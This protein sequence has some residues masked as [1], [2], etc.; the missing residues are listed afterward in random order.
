MHKFSFLF[1]ILLLTLTLPAQQDKASEREVLKSIR[2][3]ST[4]TLAAFLADGGDVNAIL[5]G[6]KKTLLNY[7]IKYKNSPAVKFLLGND[8][9]VDLISDGKTPLMFA[10][11][12]RDCQMMNL[13]LRAGADI[14][15]TAKRKNTALIFAVTNRSMP[16]VQMLVEN[17]ADA[18]YRNAKGLTALDYANLTN[19]VPM[20]EYLVHVIEMQNY[21][22]QLPAS[23]DGPHMEWL[24]DNFLRVFYMKYD[25]TIRNFLIEEKF[26]EVVGDTVQVQGFSGD[27]A[28]YTVTR[29]F[30]AEPA[31]YKDVDKILAFGD[32]HGNYRALVNFMKHHGVIDNELRWI[33]GSGHVVMMGDIFDRGDEVTEALWFLYQLDQQAHHQGG[34]V[35]T[36]LGNHEVMVMQNDTRYIDRKYELFSNYFMR[37]YASFYDT[38][39]VLGRWLRSRNAVITIND[40]LFSHAGISPAVL[41][42]QIPLAKINSVIE[43]YLNTDPDEPSRDADLMNLLLNREGPL[44]YRGYMMD[45]VFGDLISQEYVERVLQ[46]YNVDKIIIAHTEVEQMTSLYDGKV[47]LIDIPIRAS[48]MFSEALLIEK[49]RFYRLKGNGEKI[50]CDV[51]YVEKEE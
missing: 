25:T 9:N 6:Q 11:K 22:N 31:S 37:D 43:E 49:G 41:E 10:V 17:G 48:E 2:K 40:L 23:F 16:C 14:E 33:W 34:R 30:E 4:E 38:A 45:G 51:K 24:N 28:N 15:S 39:S 3:G 26:V 42:K 35:N 8:V 27:T 21:Y 20:A 13:L 7:S 5:D 18:G 44:W 32:V 12:S 46:F 29:H 50:P 47:F 1:L 36:L 19:N